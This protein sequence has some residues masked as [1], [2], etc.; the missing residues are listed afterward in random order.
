MHLKQRGFTLLRPPSVAVESKLTKSEAKQTR[1]IAS[2]RIH[3]E[4]VIRRIHHFDL[5]NDMLNY[6]EYHLVG[7]VSYV[8]MKPGGLP[9]KFGCQEGRRKRTCTSADRPYMIKKQRMSTIAECLQESCTPRT[10][11]KQLESCTPS[12]SLEQQPQTSSAGFQTIEENT[13]KVIY[14][15]T[16]DKSIQV[17]ITHKYRSKVIQTHVKTIDQAIS[18]LKPPITS[19]S[20]SPSKVTT[21]KKSRPSSSILK[22]IT[23]NILL[24][25]EQSDSDISLY[26]P[27]MPSVSTNTSSPSVHALQVKSSSDWLSVR[28]VC[29]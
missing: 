14:K 7:K 4:R 22:K 19:S 21:C 11:N 24:P 13:P 25:E 28:L 17:I 15:P 8:R 12:T 29:V 9:S 10:S 16:A 1:E 5:P 23:R 18:T 27:S 20:T 26:S 3:V 6:T 2:V